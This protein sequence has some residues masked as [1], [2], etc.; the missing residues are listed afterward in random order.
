MLFRTLKIGFGFLIILAGIFV[1]TQTVYAKTPA[2]LCDEGDASRCFI[3]A[4]ILFSQSQLD[5]ALVYYEKACD[6]G[7]VD[8]CFFLGHRAESKSN[9]RKAA[10]KK[11][12][13]F[14]DQ[15]NYAA[16]THLG[17]VSMRDKDSTMGMKSLRMACKHGDMKGCTSLGYHAKKGGDMKSAKEAFKKACNKK[18]KSACKSLEE[19]SSQR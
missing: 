3:Q 11:L 14:C 18:N 9:E 7:H 15:E 16:C 19:M 4:S 1:L 2:E 6:G 17:N 8:G 10:L 5:Q 13:E 12:E